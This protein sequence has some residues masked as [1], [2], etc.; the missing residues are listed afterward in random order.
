MVPSTRNGSQPDIVHMNVLV[1][2]SG[3]AGKNE[4]SVIG[5]KL[6]RLVLTTV[7][8]F[9]V[10][11]R[12]YCGGVQGVATGLFVKRIIKC[13]QTRFVYEPEASTAP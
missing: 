13:C 12:L 2:T 11:V 9:Q 8:P 1:V 10:T 3:S 7:T 4:A 6:A 5:R